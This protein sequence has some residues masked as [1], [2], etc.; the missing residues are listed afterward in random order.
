MAPQGQKIQCASVSFSV[1]AC[2][3]L[4]SMY[5]CICVN[6]ARQAVPGSLFFRSHRHFSCCCNLRLNLSHPGPKLSGHFHAP[7]LQTP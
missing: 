3:Y 4:V 1:H 2:M 5:L 6:T 7:P